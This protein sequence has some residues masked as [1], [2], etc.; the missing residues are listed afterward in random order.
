MRVLPRGSGRSCVVRRSRR[1]TGARRSSLLR[2]RSAAPGRR[3][4]TRPDRGFATIRHT[5]VSDPVRQAN[6]RRSVDSDRRSTAGRSTQSFSCS[7]NCCRT[8]D[9]TPATLSPLDWTD[10]FDSTMPLRRFS[11]ASTPKRRAGTRRLVSRPPSVHTS[12]APRFV[13]SHS[14]AGSCGVVKGRRGR[15]R[16]RSGLALPSRR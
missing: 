10:R 5:A 6:W 14:P 12:G 13:S 15:L 16:R 2:E 3:P 11:T 8:S 1:A 9:S 4:V 7:V